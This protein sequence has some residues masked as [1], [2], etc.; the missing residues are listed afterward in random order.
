MFPPSKW[1][2]I[3]IYIAPPKSPNFHG[4]L[5]HPPPLPLLPPCP[6]LFAASFW[7]VHRPLPSLPPIACRGRFRGARGGSP[8][9][10][11]SGTGSATPGRQAELSTARRAR[12]R[13]GAGFLWTRRGLAGGIRRGNRWGIDG[14]FKGGESNGGGESCFFIGGSSQ[15]GLRRFCEFSINLLMLKRMWKHELCVEC[16]TTMACAILAQALFWVPGT[17]AV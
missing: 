15:H 3:Y 14:P 5:P 1:I 9:A 17:Q 16:L 12:G 4:V 6:S 2:Y 7:S 11:A 8:P 10:T 13:L